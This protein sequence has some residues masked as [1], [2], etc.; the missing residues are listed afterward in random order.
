MLERTR[1]AVKCIA[2][3]GICGFC[4]IEICYY[5]VLC[6]PFSQYWAVPTNN[7][8]CATYATYSKI[9]M[10]FN[11]SSDLMIILVPTSIIYRSMLPL[12]R[13]IA[14]IGLFSLGVFTILA[15]ILNK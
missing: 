10:A 9:Q 13:K 7:S 2:I 12:K 14:L 15:A 1:L 8:Q 5:A 6:R 11:I 4:V 3:Y